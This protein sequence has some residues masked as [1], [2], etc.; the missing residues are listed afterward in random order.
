MKLAV[1]SALT[2]S[3]FGF[4]AYAGCK[5]L[6]VKN[7]SQDSVFVTSIIHENNDYSEDED[8]IIVDATF[9]QVEVKPNDSQGYKASQDIQSIFIE[10]KKLNQNV[11]YTY[12]GSGC[13]ILH[14][15]K[16][17]GV[18]VNSPHTGQI[19]INSKF[20]SWWKYSVIGCTKELGCATTLTKEFCDENGQNCKMAEAGIYDYFDDDNLSN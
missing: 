9:K 19:E 5:N 4:N 8:P 3:L 7:D 16:T 13:K 14:H 15:G 12:G 10:S 6:T 2:L 20:K 18:A 11:L 1:I 17:G